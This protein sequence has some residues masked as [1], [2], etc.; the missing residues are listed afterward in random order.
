MNGL[1]LRIYVKLQLI[2]GR[3]EGQGLVEYALVI[4]MIAFG[5]TVG[6]TFLAG[7]INAALGKISTTLGS[8]IT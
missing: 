5:A 1:L 3:E 2:A 8:S 7:A 4:P 6:M